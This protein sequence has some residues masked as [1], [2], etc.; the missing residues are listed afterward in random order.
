MENIHNTGCPKVECA[1]W[2]CYCS[3]TI[4]HID[5]NW[6][7]FNSQDYN[8]WYSSLTFVKKKRKMKKISI[9][10]KKIE[11][12]WIKKGA[13]FFPA[14]GVIWNAW[15]YTSKYLPKTLAWLHFWSIC[16]FF[17]NEFFFKKFENFF[18]FFLIQRVPPLDF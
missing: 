2:K 11:Y 16:T 6:Y 7:F 8:F 9:G 18:R 14:S 15:P 3:K 1:F 5:R 13:L 10:K 4:K 17:I 12:F